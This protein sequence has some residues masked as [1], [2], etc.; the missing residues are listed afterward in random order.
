MSVRRALRAALRR[1]ACALVAA[2]A[3]AGVAGGCAGEK[4]QHEPVLRGALPEYSAVAL[5]YNE[6][7]GLLKTLWGR[8]QVQI[9]YTDDDGDRR[10]E[11]G[12]GFLSIDQP[13]RVALSV[14]KLGETLFW[15]GCD[16]ER[17]WSIDLTQ[18]P[19]RA[20]VGRHDG[21]AR[22][23]ASDGGGRGGLA[24]TVSP[25]DLPRLLGI[26][27][28]PTGGG[29][30]QWSEDGR[31]LGVVTQVMGA[32]GGPGGRQ[33]LWLDPDSMEPR[34]VELYDARG[35]ATLVAQISEADFVA[36]P[37]LRGVGPKA[38]SRT[39]IGHLASGSS[40]NVT[41]AGMEGG[42]RRIKAEAFDLTKLMA[43]L[44]VERLVDVD[45]GNVE[46]KR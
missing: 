13:E 7:A 36:V 23:G 19:A 1:G 33:R 43:A 31:L 24:A 18:K 44:G 12:E 38:A 32:G 15:L 37:G 11:Q 46:P 41:L 45:A 9:R 42:T 14:G 16:G 10:F 25:R 26:E 5:K 34:S 3:L 39:R 35:A 40:L 6:R 20:Y 2:L 28:L 21:A 27:A 22:Q 29:V 4:E 17:Y 8:T 30:M